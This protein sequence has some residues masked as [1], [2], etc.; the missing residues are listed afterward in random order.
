[1]TALFLLVLA[2]VS[3]FAARNSGQ[4]V[5]YNISYLIVGLVALSFLIARNGVTSIR[6]SRSPRHSKLPA[7]E[8]FEE[9]IT[10]ENL[11]FIPKLWVTFYDYSTM[12]GHRFNVVVPFGPRQRRQWLVRT[13][14]TVR[15]RHR[16]GP[17]E[18]TSGDPFG[19]FH[20][21]RVIAESYRVLVYPKMEEVPV[22]PFFK[23]PLVGKPAKRHPHLTASQSVVSVREYH[24]G[25]SLSKI[26]WKVT[27]RSGRLMS[28]EFEP[29]TAGDLW[30]ILDLYGQVHWPVLDTL[31]PVDDIPINPASTE[32]AAISVAASLARKA[33]LQGRAVGLMTVGQHLEVMPPERGMPQ[34]Q[35][36]LEVLSTLRAAGNMPLEAL[37]VAQS[38]VLTGDHL[39]M[40]ITPDSSGSWARVLATGPSTKRAAVVL[41]DR[42]SFGEPQ[43]NGE[44]LAV[45]AASGIV[46]YVLKSGM[47]LALALAST[48]T[49]LGRYAGT[50]I[51]NT[52]HRQGQTPRS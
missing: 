15:G 37:L 23:G 21:S 9:L 52:Q 3:F 46:F 20:V 6:V 13:A 1:M 35:R 18:I 47:P 31:E 7:G 32:E 12:P 19:I 2:V 44:A 25:D 5:L 48:L 43:G 51:L 24:P 8:D 28:K 29:D 49:Q 26:S 38:S 50:G 45:L 36:L 39:I 27:A 33:V 11:S 40:V 14:T 42:E 4:Q 41:I 16:I 30:L 10:A 17:L 22:D 34:L